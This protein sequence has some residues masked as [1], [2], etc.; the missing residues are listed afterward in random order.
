MDKLWHSS[1]VHECTL[2]GSVAGPSFF[3]VQA[4]PEGAAYLISLDL[5]I[6]SVQTAG[7]QLGVPR[8]LLLAHDE[9]KRS[10][11]ELSSYVKNF[12]GDG[13]PDGF[14]FA[15]LHHLHNNPHH[16]QY[17]LF[18]DSWVRDGYDVVNGALPMP[19]MFAL[20]MVADWMGS[21]WAYT[22]S[23]DMS[24][25]LTKNI[26]RIILHPDTAVFVSGVLDGLGYG[27]ILAKVK[28]P[29]GACPGP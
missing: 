3:E 20:E 15:L 23:W 18:P 5:H 14:P 9:S 10:V 19:E 17:W 27:R 28:F 13:D 11:T 12:N 8:H 6:A 29:T 7:A 2:C 22:R 21:S 26:P 1:V 25:W 4:T 16:W 24:A